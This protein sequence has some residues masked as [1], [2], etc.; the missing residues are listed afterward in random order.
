M[1]SPHPVSIVVLA[2]G[3]GTRMR[4]DVPK[5]LH[6]LGG[7]PLLAHVLASARAL[8]P[9]AIHVVYGHGGAR[10]PEAFGDSHGLAWVEQAE[11]LGTGHAVQQAL[12]ELADDHTV[13]ILYGDV[14]LITAETLQRV[15]AAAAGG[16]L[17]LLVAHFD[18]PRGYGRIVRNEAGAVVRIVEEKDAS[19]LERHIKECNT[20]ILG[21]G[22]KRLRAWLAD[23]SNANAQGEYYLTDVIAMAVAEGVAVNTVHPT[24]Q[25]EILGVNDKAQLA[26]LERRFQRRQA[27]RLLAQGV[28][29]TDPARLDIRG[30]VSVG[31]D[32][33][34]DVNVVL[35]GRVVLGDGVTIGA[36]AV[37]RDC[38]LDAGSQ[39]LPMSLIEQARIGRDCRIG[40]FARIRPGTALADAV[41]VGNFVEVKNSQVE[42]GSKINHLSYVGDASV[43]RDVNVG[44]GTITCNYDGANKHRTVIG[45]NVFIGS[46]TQL[47]APVTVGDGATIGAGS[48]ITRDVPP[49]DLTLSRS[50]QQTV[51]GW[52]RPAKKA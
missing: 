15:I 25:E 40:P 9:E 20:G 38:E 43:G 48:T 16:A 23:L 11:Q 29:L 42:T 31:R 39:I 7:Q 12:P 33:S 13:L 6:P 24:R 28:T 52:K 3:Q 41:H 44:A 32:V 8:A 51:K 49:T 47:I 4:S 1:A 26:D 37:L 27:E 45:N 2:A 35:E 10:V 19:E 14:P 21:V 30:E 34:I 17:G 18:D 5:V 36:N 50:K 46:D 22:A